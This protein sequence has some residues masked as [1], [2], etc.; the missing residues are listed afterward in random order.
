MLEPEEIEHAFPTA[1]TEEVKAPTDSPVPA[2]SEQIQDMEVDHLKTD[3]EDRFVYTLLFERDRLKERLSETE[4]LHDKLRIDGGGSQHP[5]TLRALQRKESEMGDIIKKIAHLEATLDELQRTIESE[6]GDLNSHLQESESPGFFWFLTAQGRC[7]RMLLSQRKNKKIIMGIL[8]GDRPP[9]YFQVRRRA[10]MY[11][12]IA[13]SIILTLSISWQVF[14]YAHRQ[15]R[16]SAAPL[17][18]AQARDD[19]AAVQRGDIIALLD[20]IKKANLNKDIGLWESRYSRHSLELPGKKDGIVEQ[21]KNFDYRSLDYKV[22]SMTLEP[23]KVNAVIIWQM[24][25]F[26]KKSKQMKMLSQRLSVDFIVEEGKLKI[27]SVT[28]L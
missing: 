3:I 14:L 28:K 25:L 21:W 6:I 27:R 19:K 9:N 8:S 2:E 15:E 26:S 22:D 20:D 13:L 18:T 10:G 5:D 1:K 23:G 16:V 4:K 12:L 11:L 17:T 7:Y 24:Q